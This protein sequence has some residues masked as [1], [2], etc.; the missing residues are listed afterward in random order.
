MPLLNLATA[1]SGPVFP[2]NGFCGL[3]PKEERAALVSINLAVAGS[4]LSVPECGPGLW[5]RVADLDVTGVDTTCPGE[6]TF[7]DTPRVGC[8]RPPSNSG[9]CALASFCLPD[10][11]EYSRVCG[12]ITGR[13]AGNP[14]GYNAVFTLPGM[15]DGVTLTYAGRTK[16]IWSF[17]AAGGTGGGGVECPCNPVGATGLDEATVNFI[18]DN[19]FCEDALGITDALW[20]GTDCTPLAPA[21]CC[22]LNPRPYFTV[23]LDSP[24][25]E[26]IEARICTGQES[27]N[28]QVFVQMMEIFIQ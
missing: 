8:T 6:W 16:H 14:N 20:T 25:M 15:V 12:R 23:T 11:V 18:G 24:T 26:D 28:E 2:P 19:Y 13:A 7:L 3:S 22:S 17:V 21:E 5:R 9:G 27:A 4:F 1:S 10:G